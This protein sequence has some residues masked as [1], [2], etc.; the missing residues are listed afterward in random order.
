LLR[1]AQRGY[2]KK[3]QAGRRVQDSRIVQR[4]TNLY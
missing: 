1:K 3:R 2:N 4:L